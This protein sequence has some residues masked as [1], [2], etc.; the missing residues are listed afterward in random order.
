MQ[1]NSEISP[2]YLD[3]CLH[4]AVYGSSRETLEGIMKGLILLIRAGPNVYA[5]DGNGY[6]VSDHVCN[7]ETVFLDSSEQVPEFP[8]LYYHRNCNLRLREIWKE[9]LSACGHDAEEV[10]SS[11][12]RARDHPETEYQDPHEDIDVLFEDESECSHVGLDEDSGTSNAE[13]DYTSQSQDLNTLRQ[14]SSAFY[15]DHDWSVLE[16]DTNVWGS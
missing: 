4:L 2:Q 16:E 9:A 10:I 12:I 11:S 7:P 13:L 15:S 1:K 3:G 8:C 5:R 14:P 6:S